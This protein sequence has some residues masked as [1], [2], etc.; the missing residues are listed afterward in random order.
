VLEAGDEE[1]RLLES[2]FDNICDAEL[3]G[4]VDLFLGDPAL[5]V[6][7][8]LIRDIPLALLL[9]PLFERISIVVQVLML[10]PPSE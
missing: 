1:L 9:I 5:G 2:T 6:E 7:E 8:D 3:L 4:T 10:A